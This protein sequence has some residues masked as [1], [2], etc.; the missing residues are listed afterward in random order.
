M[1]RGLRMGRPEAATSRSGFTLIETMVVVSV[2]GLLIALL[3]PAVQASREAARKGAVRQQ[4]EA[5]RSGLA[6]LRSVVQIVSA[7]LGGTPSGPPPRASVAHL[8]SA[9]L[10]A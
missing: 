10:S 5:D 3:L 7:Q 2:I 6:Q 9:L 8:Q 1:S 4:L